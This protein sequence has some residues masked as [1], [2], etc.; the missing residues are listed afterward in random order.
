[1]KTQIVKFFGTMIMVMVFTTVMAKTSDF[2][3]LSTDGHKKTEISANAKTAENYTVKIFD[4]KGKI[5][6]EE[7]TSSIIQSDVQNLGS[8]PD[9]YYTFQVIHGKELVYRAIIAKNDNGQASFNDLPGN[10]AATI[11]QLDEMIL[12]RILKNDRGRASITLTNESNE[13]VYNRRTSK[14]G[15]QR[16]THDLSKLPE[17]KYTMNVY[18]NGVLLAQKLISK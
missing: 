10:A 16:I 9:G 17:G 14:P 1:M 2:E 5:V 11:S 15:C 13:I 12:V 7:I 18:N 4:N 6:F 3:N 8:L